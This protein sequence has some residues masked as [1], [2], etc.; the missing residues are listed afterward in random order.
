MDKKIRAFLRSIVMLCNDLDI[1]TIA[2]WVETEEQAELL[3]S[4]GV[5]Y[6]QG[7]LYG[8]PNSG[9]KAIAS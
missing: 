1:E 5:T 6:A 2:E 7:Y 8:R 9:I 4:L 3:R